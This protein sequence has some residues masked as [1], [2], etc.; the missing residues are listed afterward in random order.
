MVRTQVQL[1]D[2]ESRKVKRSAAKHN[3]SVAEYI[4]RSLDKALR[5][6]I[7][8]DEEEIRR[9]AIAAVGCGH[10]GLKDVSKR[11]D[12]YLVEAYLE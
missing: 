6:E 8:P 7:I 3:V 12:D 11:I 1:T 9:R 2:E 4:R 10:S 5:S